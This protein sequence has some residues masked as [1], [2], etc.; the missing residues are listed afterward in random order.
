VV[1]LDSPPDPRIEGPAPVIVRLDNVPAIA[2]RSPATVGEIAP[3][4]PSFHFSDEPGSRSVGR[5]LLLARTARSAVTFC[6]ASIRDV[7]REREVGGE[8]VLR[9]L[10]RHTTPHRI[11]S[12]SADVDQIVAGAFREANAVPAR[13]VARRLRVSRSGPRVTMMLAPTTDRLES[14]MIRPRIIS[15]TCRGLVVPD[16][17]FDTLRLGIV[18]CLHR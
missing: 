14:S 1:R 4:I 9:R 16:R 13:A 2:L 17:A 11:E 3:L 5:A 7:A 10:A 18:S 8:L 12:R 6:A 15:G